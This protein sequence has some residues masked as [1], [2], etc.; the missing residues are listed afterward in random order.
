MMPRPATIN[1]CRYCGQPMGG[2]HVVVHERTCLHNPALLA[3]LQRILDD[4][5][6]RCIRRK[7]YASMEYRPVAAE[8]I[9]RHFGSWDAAAKA[10]GLSI[11]DKR[12][13]TGWNAPL[14]DA[15]RH[16]CQRRGSAEQAYYPSR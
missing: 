5:T 9:V 3:E 11:P 8:G 1:H 10:L 12:P 4:G 16:A 13:K 14:T 15:E 6:G 7:I 2:N